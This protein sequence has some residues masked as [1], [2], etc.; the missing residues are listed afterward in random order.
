MM[1]DAGAAQRIAAEAGFPE[2]ARRLGT[3]EII[4]G[5]CGFCPKPVYHFP[6]MAAPVACGNCASYLKACPYCGQT[7]DQRK[8][9][10]KGCCTRECSDARDREQRVLAWEASVPLDFRDTDV[11]KLPD[12]PAYAAVMAWG[13]NYLETFDG[14]G[15]FMHGDPGTGKTRCAYL[16]AHAIIEDGCSVGFLR[17]VDFADEV[18]ER[19]MPQGKGGFRPW[20]DRLVDPGVL[21]IDDL[22]KLSPS[23]RVVKELY[24]LLDTRAGNQA[25]MVITSN[26][27][28]TEW[29]K[30][31]PD[32]HG[33]AILRR[34]REKTAGIRFTITA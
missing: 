6:H 29:G 30:A 32:G 12:Q 22:D 3:G 23:T 24:T 28:L 21:F 13:A 5:T 19:T 2:I 1:T 31:L 14:H 7:F 11:G 25:P 17:G 34:I 27:R 20:F 15:L 16:L 33:P 9:R 8:S 26:K 10:S 4:S 18:V